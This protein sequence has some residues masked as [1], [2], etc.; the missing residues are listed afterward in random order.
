VASGD[1]WAGA[2]VQLAT[3][4]K[5]LVR[6]KD[7]GV[8]AIFLNE[9]RLV[10]EARQCAID[11][12]VVPEG[13]Y[14]FLRILSEASRFLGGKKVQILHSHRYKEN[15][16]AALLTRRSGIPF[17]VCSRHGAREP[18]TGWQRYKQH[19][20]QAM[21][22]LVIRYSTDRVVSVSEELRT[23]LTRYLPTDKVVTIYNGVDAGSVFSPL[24]VSEAKQ[25]L[26]IPAGC[27]VVGTAGRLDPIKRL[28]IFLAAAQEIAVSQ[29]KA[30]FVIAGEGKEESSLRALARRL[31]VQDRVLFLGH[32]TDVYDVLRAMDI[33]VL[34]S[35]HEG[36]PMSLLETLYLGVPVVARPVGGVAE[37]IQD[38]VS[39]V[40]VQSSE[41]SALAAACLQL[42]DDDARR[43]FLARAGTGVIARKFTADRT[44]DL[45][46][47]LYRS[48]SDAR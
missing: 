11:V 19:L 28:D 44:A 32:R 15:L 12:L 34:C 48:L 14:S 5:A 8:S 17:H 46:A 31:G 4:I 6:R 43:I 38:G 41:P 40:W 18:F 25:R 35:D 13:K 27:W 26:G 45:L 33:F 29:P 7:L 2:E 36:L 10:E 9:G 42:F 23:Q 47:Q 22:R 37:V 21:D 39:G 3:L 24:S 1:R 20:I 16:L 30:R